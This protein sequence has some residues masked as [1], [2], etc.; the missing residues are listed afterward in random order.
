MSSFGCPPSPFMGQRQDTGPSSWMNRLRLDS[1]ES[2]TA[3]LSFTSMADHQVLLIS[4]PR[5][6]LS[7]PSFLYHLCCHMTSSSHLS[8]LNYG[9]SFQTG[10]SAIFQ[11]AFHPKPARESHLRGQLTTGPSSK[12]LSGPSVARGQCL[13]STKTHS[14]WPDLALLTHSVTFL[15]HQT[16]CNST[17]Y[18]FFL[19]LHL[20]SCCALCLGG[21]PIPGYFFPFVKLLLVFIYPAWMS[22]PS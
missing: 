8:H 19:P 21:L 3:L 12:C 1:R 16:I 6:P 22:F 2:P 18:G 10:P 11:T 15:W 5:P 20:C 17:I 13:S 9:N 4:P 7:A 14:P